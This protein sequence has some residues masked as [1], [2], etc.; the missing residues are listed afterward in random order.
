MQT[1]TVKIL[2]LTNK[3]SHHKTCILLLLYTST[4]NDVI[5]PVANERKSL[6]SKFVRISISVKI[7][8]NCSSS[9]SSLETVRR[10]VQQC[11]MRNSH[12]WYRCWA[13]S[14]SQS[15]GSQPADNLVISPVVGHHYFLPDPVTF[16]D[17]EHCCTLAGTKLYCLVTRGTWVWITCLRLLCS[18][19]KWESNL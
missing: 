3:T 18:S 15:Y 2:L 19:A 5:R 14:W 11:K 12:N 9:T 8:V 6:D 13:W 10:P 4:E 7:A 17:K 16:P 1:N